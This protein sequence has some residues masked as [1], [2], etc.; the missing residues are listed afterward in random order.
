MNELQK[1]K[2]ERI[3]DVINFTDSKLGKIFKHLITCCDEEDFDVLTEFDNA[4]NN[5]KRKVFTFNEEDVKDI[6]DAYPAR[7]VVTGRNL[8]KNTGDKEK[9]ARLLK[10]RSREDLISTI[11]KY[12]NDCRTRK[13]YMKNFSTF[14]NNIPDYDDDDTKIDVKDSF[15]IIIGMPTEVKNIGGWQE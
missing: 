14:L 1:L 5:R 15:S 8:G 3:D 12:V 13:V 4:K 11:Q 2:K 6:Y 7:C 10:Y 9:I